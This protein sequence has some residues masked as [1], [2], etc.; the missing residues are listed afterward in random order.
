MMFLW[1]FIVGILAYLLFAKPRKPLGEKKSGETAED[2][3]TMRY[4]N[5]EITEEEYKRMQKII[6]QQEV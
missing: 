2:V 1:I 4:V 6:N 5:G 3:L